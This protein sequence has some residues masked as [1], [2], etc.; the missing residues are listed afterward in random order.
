MGKNKNKEKKE[1]KFPLYINTSDKSTSVVGVI[2]DTSQT[3]IDGKGY[4]K[5]SDKKDDNYNKDNDN[6]DNKDNDNKKVEVWIFCKKKPPKVS[7]NS[8]PFFW[9]EDGEFKFSN[10]SEFMKDIYT[11]DNLRDLSLVNIINKTIPGEQLYNEQEILD[12][13]AAS[14]T[15]TPRIEKDDDFLKK[16]V[17]VIINE[18]KIDINKLKSRVDLPYVLPNMRTALANKTKMSV[19]YFLSW[20]ELLGCSFEII[21]KDN[22]E[23]KENPLAFDHIFDI[24][25][26]KTYINMNGKPVLLDISQYRK[27]ETPE[28]PEDDVPVSLSA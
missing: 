14:S 15:F 13:N 22:G 11:T 21:V 4:L 23:D 26:D 25:T 2:T 5:D 16:I 10:P 18:K 12:I 7:R 19:V 20:M 17:K 1:F 8:Y 28:N 9:I 24:E 6:D 3:Y 27:I